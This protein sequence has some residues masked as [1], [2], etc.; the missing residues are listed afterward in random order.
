M[1]TMYWE[2]SGRLLAAVLFAHETA[3]LD[4]DVSAGLDVH[5]EEGE[6]APAGV[7]LALPGDGT[8]WGQRTAQTW[9]RVV[10]RV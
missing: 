9:S 3:A 4:A 2:L 1:I 7:D 10:I 8:R 5:G 6:G